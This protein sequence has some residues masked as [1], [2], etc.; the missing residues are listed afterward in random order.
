MN[1]YL[2]HKWRQFTDQDTKVLRENKLIKSQ[3]KQKTIALPQFR[4]NEKWG[5]PGST[6]RKNIRV[7][8]RQIVGK[9]LPQKIAYINNFINNCKEECIRGRG[10]SQILSNLVLLDS[11]AS[12]IYE[13]NYATGGFLFEAFLAALYGSRAEQIPAT[14][15][16]TG[17]SGADIADILDSSRNP[18]SLKFYKAGKGKGSKQVGG[19]L[20]DLRHSVLKYGQPMKYLVVLKNEGDQG[21]VDTIDFYEFTVGSRGRRVGDGTGPMA[22]FRSTPSKTTTFFAEDFIKEPKKNSP[23][24]EIPLGSIKGHEP[25]A[26]LDFGSQEDLKGLASKYVEQLQNEVTVIYNNLDLLTNNINRYLVDNNKTAGTKA[27]TNASELHNATQ[28]LIKKGP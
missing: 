14:Q 28:I 27:A 2:N 25:V 15:T 4:I 24:W 21:A 22:K 18:V 19:S 8:F 23:R 3:Q 1:D 13:Y 26:I 5:E 11:L 7:F 12:I 6:D 10:T 20:R 9:T 17:E 16:K